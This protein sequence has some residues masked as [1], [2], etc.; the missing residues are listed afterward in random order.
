MTRP[1][2]YLRNDITGKVIDKKLQLLSLVDD[3][4]LS[5]H[6]IFETADWSTEPPDSLAELYKKRAAQIR[7]EYDYI[8]LYFSGGSDSITMLNAF[9]RNN[10]KVDEVVVYVNTDFQDLSM[11]GALALKTLRELNFNEKLTVVNVNSKLLSHAIQNKIW[12]DYHSFSGLLHSFYRF[13]ISFYEKHSYIKS[14]SRGYNTAHL[15]GGMF[16]DVRVISNKAYFCIN[17]KQTMISSLDPNNVQFFT[18]SSMLELHVKQCYVIAKKMIELGGT[19]SDETEELKLSIR[20]QYD[21]NLHL[22]KN[23]GN[24]ETH[25]HT[26]NIKSQHFKLYQTVPCDYKK[27]VLDHLEPIQKL[28][29]D[30]YEQQYFLFDV[31]KDDM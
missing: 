26:Q 18:D 2:A 1:I 4:N 22:V 25:N 10:I 9:M 5:F 6:S 29:L 21:K 31:K 3:K 7:S 20:D 19:E 15:F 30:G 14:F 12:Q 16:P 24:I 17:L 23:K 28:S 27:N 8:V 13:R 11:N